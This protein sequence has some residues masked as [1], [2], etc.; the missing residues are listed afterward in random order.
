MT[1]AT[2]IAYGSAIG[3][4]IC[5]IGDATEAFSGGYNVTRDF[6]MF[7]DSVAYNSFKTTSNIV[8]S[9]VTLAGLIGSKIIQSIAKSS[10]ISKISKKTGEIVGYSKDFFDSKSNWVLRIDASTH[11]NPG[12]APWH[13]DPHIHIGSRSGKGNAVYY[14]WEVIKEWL[15]I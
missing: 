9:I 3:T 4:A 6:L 5:G 2:S 13:H 10:G 1:I 15:N 8:G 7:G 12:A 14:I 11:G